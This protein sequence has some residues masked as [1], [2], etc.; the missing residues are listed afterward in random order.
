MNWLKKVF[1]P[2]GIVSGLLLVTQLPE[3]GKSDVLAASI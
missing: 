2:L 1:M 3:T